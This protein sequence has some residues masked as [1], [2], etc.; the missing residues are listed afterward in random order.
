MKICTIPV[1]L[2]HVRVRSRLP[3]DE[4]QTK[5]CPFLSGGAQ[6]YGNKSKSPR[7]AQNDD[8]KELA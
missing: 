7:V 6:S 3:C 4:N 2:I 5:Q 1:G 8:G